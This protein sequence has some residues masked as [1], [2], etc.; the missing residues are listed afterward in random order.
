MAALTETTF[1]L[2][3]M[4]YIHFKMNQG[5]HIH[6]YRKYSEVFS[7]GSKFTNGKLYFSILTEWVGPDFSKIIT[8]FCV[9]RR[10]K[11]N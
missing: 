8:D 1:T 5:F 7:P 10:N 3:G 2:A 9:I 11:K 4:V 6:I